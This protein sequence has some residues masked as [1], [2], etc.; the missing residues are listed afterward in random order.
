M[1]VGIDSFA[2]RFDEAGLAASPVDRMHELL[3]RIEHA[4]HVGLD[5]FGIGEHHKREFLDSAP[6]VILPAAASRTR[7]FV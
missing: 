2:A 1:E 4:D 6:P 7:A 3:E 5:V